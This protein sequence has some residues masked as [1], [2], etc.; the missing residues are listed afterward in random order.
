MKILLIL[1]CL[2]LCGGLQGK[3]LAQGGGKAEPNRISFRK[4]AT[5]ATVS[6]YLKQGEQMEYVFGATKG[7]KVSLKIVSTPKGEFHYFTVHGSETD[8]V[9]DYDINF[10]WT[11]DAPDT[12]DFLVFVHMRATDKVRSGRFRLTITI[13]P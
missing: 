1:M 9:S 3:A 13:K 12:G 8:F 5:S 11:F 7:Q 6:G 2:C 4:G 10:E